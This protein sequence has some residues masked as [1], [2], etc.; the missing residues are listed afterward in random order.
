[1]S[2]NGESV[3]ICHLRSM[4]GVGLGTVEAVN[5]LWNLSKSNK[6]LT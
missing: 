3:Y 6:V 2:G 4:S 1:M 5:F